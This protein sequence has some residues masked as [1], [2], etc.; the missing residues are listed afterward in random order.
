[1]VK[2]VVDAVFPLAEARA[3]MEMMERREQFGKIL[4]KP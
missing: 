2:P 1:V 3:A 4:V